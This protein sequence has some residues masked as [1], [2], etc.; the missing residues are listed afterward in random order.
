LGFEF[1]FL[2]MLP[3]L[4]FGEGFRDGRVGCGERGGVVVECGDGGGEGAVGEVSESLDVEEACGK[5]VRS[6]CEA[7]TQPRTENHHLEARE[8]GRDADNDL[9]GRPILAISNDL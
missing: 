8:Q 3:F 2:R 1:E 9:A 5:V 6:L 4:P 7:R